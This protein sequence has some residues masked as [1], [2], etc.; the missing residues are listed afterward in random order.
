MT[1]LGISNNLYS[2]NK[3]ASLAN[4]KREVSFGGPLNNEF[5]TSICK[6]KEN[7]VASLLGINMASMV[8][9]QTIIDF[10]RNKQAGIETSV[11]QLGGIFVN[12]LMYGALSSAI[13]LMGLRA[14]KILPNANKGFDISN[15]SLDFLGEQWKNAKGADTDKRLEAYVENVVNGIKAKTGTEDYKAL[16]LGDNLDDVVKKITSAIKNHS[17]LNAVLNPSASKSEKITVLNSILDPIGKALGACDNISHDGGFK[18]SLEQLIRDT[19]RAGQDIF[20]QHGDDVIKDK[21]A[22]LKALN[23]TKLGVTLAVVMAATFSIQHINRYLTKLRTGKDGFVGYSD[24]DKNKQNPT[25]TDTKQE[26]PKTQGADKKKQV[27]F[28]GIFPGED[29]L[30]YLIYPANIS[31][32]LTAV[33]DKN[34]LAE[35]TVKTAI[36]YANL[37]FIPALVANLGAYLASKFTKPPVVLENFKQH[38]NIDNRQIGAIFNLDKNAFDEGKIGKQLNKIPLLKDARSSI[39][40]FMKEHVEPLYKTRNWLIEVNDASTKSYREIRYFAENYV[41]NLGDDVLKGLSKAEAKE[42]IVKHLKGIKNKSIIAGVG[43]ACITLGII[44]PKLCAKWTEYKHKKELESKA[45]TPPAA[46]NIQTN[47]PKEQKAVEVQQNVAN[48]TNQNNNL[49]DVLNKF[50]NKNP[51]S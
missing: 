26:T 35:A 21:I 24:F 47:K 48:Q 28:G 36:G 8:I 12:Y 45:Q 31:G 30:K 6:L 1:N 11:F 5:V 51:L 50:K 23:K 39:L 29:Q 41:E 46:Q 20:S 10:Q 42:Q 32:R 17:N 40:N 37:M 49:D 9:P 2:Y 33:R 15:K 43:Y 44:I 13:G 18:G 4:K 16:N 7:K 38:V 3:Q 22:Q 25:K 19:H 34:E 27:S 14:L